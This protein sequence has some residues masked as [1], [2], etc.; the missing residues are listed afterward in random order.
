MDKQQQII[1]MREEIKFMIWQDLIKM[2]MDYYQKIACSCMIEF[3]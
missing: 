3:I 2:Q 1:K